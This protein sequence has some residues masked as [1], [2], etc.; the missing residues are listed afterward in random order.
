MKGLFILRTRGGIEREMI[1]MRFS[2]GRAREVK[3]P[4]GAYDSDPN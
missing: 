1:S 3:R 4:K 2:K